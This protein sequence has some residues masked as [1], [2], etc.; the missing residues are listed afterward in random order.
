MAVYRPLDEALPALTGILL[1]MS[2]LVADQFTE[3]VD[4]LVRCDTALAAE[5]RRRDDEVDAMELEVDR[6][7]ERVLALDQ[8]VAGDL[9]A[10]IIA[11]KI[12]NDLERIGDHAKNIAKDVPHVASAPAAIGATHLP[13]MAD[14]VRRMLREAHEAFRQRDRAMASRV[15]AYDREVDRLHKANFEALDAHIRAHPG[16]FV[17]AAHL[18]TASKSM[19]RIA[20]HAKNV[21]RGVV[22]ILEGEDLRHLKQQRRAAEAGAADAGAAPATFEDD[23][24]A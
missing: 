20:D 1:R 13:E 16:D 22:F 24:L 11:V 10:L 12:N 18:L 8:P 6:V 14:A 5:V 21:A 23:D 7:A 4:A 15:M 19:E 9:R 17:A 3:A 2:D